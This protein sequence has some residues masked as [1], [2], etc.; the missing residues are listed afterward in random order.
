MNTRRT[1]Y[2]GQDGHEYAVLE[3]IDF[4]RF[5]DSELYRF[6]LVR[7]LDW[8]SADVVALFIMLNPSTADETYDDP[9]IRRCKDFAL[10]AGCGVLSVVNLSPRRAT[11]PDD[12]IMAGPEEPEVWQANLKNILSA[13]SL[14]TRIVLAYGVNGCIENRD[15][16]VITAL[17]KHGYGD[18]LWC[19]GVTKNGYP[20]HPLYVPKTQPMV[21]YNWR[22]LYGDEATL[23]PAIRKQRNKATRP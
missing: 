13:A 7:T 8:L 4:A 18:D 22:V 14:A 12:L 19:L 3:P 23:S 2:L 20:R 9:T 1:T 21:L 17:I 6:S 16:K 5:G 11:D 10:R 15:T